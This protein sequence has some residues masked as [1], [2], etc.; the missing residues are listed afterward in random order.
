MNSPV[1]PN[2]SNPPVLSTVPVDPELPAGSIMR[3]SYKRLAS[4][5]ALFTIMM[6]AATPP[7]HA[8][9][10]SMPWEQPLQ[11]ILQ[12]IEGPVAKIVAVIIII[13]T[14]LALAFGDTSGGFRR[15]IQIVFGLSIAFAASSFFLSFFSFGGGV[16]V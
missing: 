3:G 11:Q 13:A 8:S 7:A 2:V 1:I 6:L 9:G 14:G 15:L 12:S 4:S 5:T 16:L 10:S